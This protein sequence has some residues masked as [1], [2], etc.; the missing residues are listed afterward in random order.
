MAKAQKHGT[1]SKNVN[2]YVGV[3]FAVDPD[4]KSQTGVAMIIGD[5]AQTCINQK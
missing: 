3:A 2:G 4:F 1:R 5:E